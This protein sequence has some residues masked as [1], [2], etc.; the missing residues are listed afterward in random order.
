[1]VEACLHALGRNLIVP[2]LLP[3]CTI[4]RNSAVSQLGPIAGSGVLA[5]LRLA[6]MSSQ[7]LLVKRERIL[8][9]GYSSVPLGGPKGV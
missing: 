8:V 2:P 4:R 6:L 1:M 5:E 7:R 9:D 3:D